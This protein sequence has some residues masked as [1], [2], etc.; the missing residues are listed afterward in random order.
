MPRTHEAPN[1]TS[2]GVAVEEL[3]RDNPDLLGA[4][5]VDGRG[6][7][8][9]ADATTTGVIEAAVA[10]IVPARELL[11]RVAAELGCGAIKSLVLEGDRASMAFAD[12]DGSSTAI[13]IGQNGSAPGALRSDALSL[14]ERVARR[15]GM[16][17]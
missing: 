12:V 9:A 3:R 6:A 13:V 8:R 2:T 5:I 15:G 1:A 17:S 16:A 7:I 10:L 11:D 14:S 4:L